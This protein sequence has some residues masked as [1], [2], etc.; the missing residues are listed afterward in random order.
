MIVLNYTFQIKVA[1]ST[2]ISKI[3]STWHDTTDEPKTR[4]MTDN[5]AFNQQHKYFF[6]LNIDYIINLM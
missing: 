6:L 3:L 1:R 2:K 4:G 5:A